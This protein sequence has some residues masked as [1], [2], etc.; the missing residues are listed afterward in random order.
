[1][2]VCV[3]FLVLASVGYVSCIM[4]KK[5]CPLEEVYR[6]CSFYDE[7]TCWTKKD[8]LYRVKHSPKRLVHCRSGCYCKNNLVREYPGGLC[9]S[10]QFCRNRNLAMTLAKLPAEFVGF[11]NL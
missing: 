10:S 9:I 7:Y 5:S 1:M 8:H 3:A 11:G 6:S 2:N 4:L